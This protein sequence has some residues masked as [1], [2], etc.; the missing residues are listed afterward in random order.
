M[1]SA[2]HRLKADDAGVR[3]RDSGV[4]AAVNCS[5]WPLGYEL[6]CPD[7]YNSNIKDIFDKSIKLRRLKSSLTDAVALGGQHPIV[8]AR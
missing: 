2:L 3:R 5:T 8:R 1:E 7:I 6:P 4:P